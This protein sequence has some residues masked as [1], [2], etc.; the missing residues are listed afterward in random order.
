MFCRSGTGIRTTQDQVKEVH[1][2]ASE[3]DDK[4]SDERLVTGSR[5]DAKEQL[6]PTRQ[7]LARANKCLLMKI[8]VFHFD[9]N[10]TLVTASNIRVGVLGIPAE[11]LEVLIEGFDFPAFAGV[12]D[13]NDY[14]C[15]RPHTGGVV[16]LRW[17]KWLRHGG[18]LDRFGGSRRIWVV[19]PEG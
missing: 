10:V 16:A 5:D 1:L 9:L 7:Q 6:F 11:V 19:C 2:L 4:D 8:N 14:C 12:E 17:R 13:R 3:A 18:G 15:I